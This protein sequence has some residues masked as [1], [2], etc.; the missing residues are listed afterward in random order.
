MKVWDRT[1]EPTLSKAQFSLLLTAFTA[2]GIGVCMWLATWTRNVDLMQWGGW[3]LFGI[4]IVVLAAG[5]AGI[6]IADRSDKPWQSALGFLLVAGPM[7]LLIGPMLAQYPTDLVLS[8]GIQTTVLVVILGFIGA[9]IPK[10]LSGWGNWLLGALIILIVGSLAMP[11]LSLVGVSVEDG[12][13]WWNWIGVFVFGFMVIYE[14]N[15]AMRVPF[16]VDNAID[17]SIGIFLD[18]LNLFLRLLANSRS[19]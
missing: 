2:L 1:N 9:L 6:V 14:L 5:F 7:G 12:Y 15:K 16:T 10:D 19:S 17:C 8:I 3:G 4:V 13:Y 11:M 18:W